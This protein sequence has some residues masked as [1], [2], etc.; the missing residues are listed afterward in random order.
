MTD[1][2]RPCT[3]D[4]GLSS[5]PGLRRVRRLQRSESERIL[6]WS[7]NERVLSVEKQTTNNK[8]TNKQTNKNKKNGTNVM[9]HCHSTKATLN[10]DL[11]VI[12]V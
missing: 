10:G 7:A 3:T 9:Q 1:R 8:Q 12:F 5:F 6:R 11:W 2:D 4:L